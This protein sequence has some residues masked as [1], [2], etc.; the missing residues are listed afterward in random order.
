MSDFAIE[1]IRAKVCAMDFV[2]GTLA[3]IALW[4]DD[5]AEP[6]ANLVVDDMIP[7]PIEYWRLC[8][9]L[10]PGSLPAMK[11]AIVTS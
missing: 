4:R 2:R 8:P 9:C 7:T 11:A 1:A 10:R 5:I 3:E 6:Q